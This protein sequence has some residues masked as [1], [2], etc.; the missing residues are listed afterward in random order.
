[1]TTGQPGQARMKRAVVYGEHLQAKWFCWIARG[2]YHRL[3][4]ALLPIFT[5][6][7]SKMR[8][9]QL[10]LSWFVVVCQRSFHGFKCCILN[11]ADMYSLILPL[12]HSP[13][14]SVHTHSTLLWVCGFR[15]WLRMC[16]MTPALPYPST[17]LCGQWKS[18]VPHRATWGPPHFL[19][20]NRSICQWAEST[21]HF[22]W[23]A[24]GK[25]GGYKSF[26]CFPMIVN[27]SI[28][29]QHCVVSKITYSS[30]RL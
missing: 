14:L 23:G 24:I 28:S 26:W 8:L 22:S 19:C 5:A 21:T 2:F 25:R 18:M 29:K 7:F 1:M 4:P 10:C 15:C 12:S 17:A 13:T 20:H 27:F 6:H 30:L 3:I 16:L 11:L 9:L